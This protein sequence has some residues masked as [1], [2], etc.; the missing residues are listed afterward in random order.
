MKNFILLLC[1]VALAAAFFREPSLKQE[2]LKVA[3]ELTT[4][5]I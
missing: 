3:Y 4:R 5:K 2:D 1:F